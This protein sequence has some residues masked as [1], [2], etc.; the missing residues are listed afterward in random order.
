[1]NLKKS[2][3]VIIVIASLL[4]GFAGGFGGGYYK[5]VHAPK[6]EAQEAAKKQQEE[7]NKMVRHGE[8]VSVEP[9][10]LTMKVEKGGGDIGKTITAKVTEYTS[11]QIGMGFVNKPGEKLD[12]T[13]WFKQGDSVD[14]LY[15]DGQAMA[16]HRELRQGE[17]E[18]QPSQA[19]PVQGQ[20]P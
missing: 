1:M 2:V 8:V 6:V 4:V 9:D 14:M 3:L 11:A 18:P 12:L 17:Q 10:K 13:K 15:K 7:L 19:P 5:F 16:L 20:Q